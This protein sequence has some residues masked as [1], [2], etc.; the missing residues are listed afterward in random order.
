[1]SK[2][3]VDSSCWIELFTGGKRASACEKR[4][5][6]TT[7]ILVPTLV[8]YEVY[9]KIATKVGEAQSLS[10]VGYLSQN[11]V[12]LL[13]RATSLYAADL[14]IELGLPMA[15]SIILAHSRIERAELMTLD[16]DFLGIDG[17]NVLR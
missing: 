4:I 17:V 8:I 1:M 3:L 11:Q 13:D 12:L 2:L 10:A 5:K 16:D 6:R 14:S 7:S 9:K 15:D